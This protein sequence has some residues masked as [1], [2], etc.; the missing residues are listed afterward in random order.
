M[1]N[2][3]PQLIEEAVKDCGNSDGIFQ[4]LFYISNGPH[5][6]SESVHMRL[7]MLGLIHSLPSRIDH[8][9]TSFLTP[10]GEQVLCQI[11]SKIAAPESAELVNASLLKFNVRYTKQFNAVRDI[12]P[13][14]IKLLQALGV[15]DYQNQS[16]ERLESFL[17]DQAELQVLA[18]DNKS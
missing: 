8:G 4:N 17:R 15:L 7:L 3:M 16:T 6:P 1:R 14:G 5:T 10:K 9:F 13:Q 12:E 2:Q 11:R 18:S